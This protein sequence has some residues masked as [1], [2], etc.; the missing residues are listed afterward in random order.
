MTRT[1]ISFIE[2]L[3]SP[4]IH[5]EMY[6]NGNPSGMNKTTEITDNAGTKKAP[7]EMSPQMAAIISPIMVALY[8]VIFMQ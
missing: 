5:E 2:E 4:K 7:K 8:L 1:P 6:S 3:F